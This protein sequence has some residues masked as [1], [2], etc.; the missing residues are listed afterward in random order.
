LEA[1]QAAQLS[2]LM[3]INNILRVEIALN[4][5]RTEEEQIAAIKNWWAENGTQLIVGVLVVALGYFGYQGWQTKQQDQSEAAADIYE[6]LQQ[7]VDASSVVQ[8]SLSE[9]ELETVR[10]IGYLAD[11]LQTEY[12]D[13]GYSVLGAI[14][15][16]RAAADRDDYAEA[17]SRLEWVLQADTDPATLQLA[18][19]RIA[20]AKA[21]SGAEQEAITLL[22]GEDDSYAALYAESRGDIYRQSGENAAAAIQYELAIEKLLPEQSNYKPALEFK[23]ANVAAGVAVLAAPAQ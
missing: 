22:S 12:S 18:T 1:Y 19:Y 5:M 6:S 11:Q 20:L 8:G 23:L 16:A 21:A 13:T 4:D 3:H 2:L 17:I 14:A 9:L 10:T 7:G 15:A